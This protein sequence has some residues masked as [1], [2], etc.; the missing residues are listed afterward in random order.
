MSALRMRLRAAARLTAGIAVT[1][2]LGVSIGGCGASSIALDPVARAA[3][4]TSGAGG[5]HTALTAQVEAGSLPA[6]F[7]MSGRGFF[8]YHTREGMLTLQLSG[9][10]ESA[11][12]SLPAGP[13]R[14]EEIFKS[15]TI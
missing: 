11:G 5:A 8:N 14:M 10:P 13:L 15:S 12:T 4:A 3:A 9:L 2:A 6:P 1:V 7:T